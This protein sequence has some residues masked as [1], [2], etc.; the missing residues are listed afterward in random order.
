MPIHY[1]NRVN[2]VRSFGLY[3]LA[4]LRHMAKISVHIPR[5]D[6]DTSN[7]VKHLSFFTVALVA[8][9][10][11][12]V[13][14]TI[15]PLRAQADWRCTKDTNVSAPM[16][17]SCDALCGEAGS[18]GAWQYNGKYYSSALRCEQ[19]KGSP[20]SD[21]GEFV[22]DFPETAEIDPPSSSPPDTSGICQCS[23]G[24]AFE[25]QDQLSCRSNTPGVTCTFT[26]NLA[27][28]Q[29]PPPTP[30]SGNIPNLP[31]QPTPSSGSC[32]PATQLC[33]P[34][35]ANTFAELVKSLANALVA[36]AIPFVVI[37]LIWSG[38]LFVSARGN[39]Q[40]ITKAKQTF[41]WTILGAAVV[42]GAYALAS[43][44]VHFAQSLSA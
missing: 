8:I 16:Q 22:S 44:V 4:L 3:V 11:V 2:P 40:Q 41:Y 19:A 32:D 10:L 35:A 26:S 14:L 12:V 38:F 37:F 1:H 25:V 28:P 24:S 17:G 43:A 39:E 42:V 36:I 5:K 20:C 31:T 7:G 30:P 34:L 9:F 27:S 21:V 29:L 33:N 18:C 15:A 6:N 23:N 13:L